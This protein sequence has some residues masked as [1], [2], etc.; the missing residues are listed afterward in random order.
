M[1]LVSLFALLML[2]VSCGQDG[3]GSSSSKVAQR[4]DASCELNGRSVACG[5]IR[6]ADGE[7]VDL[8]E[9]LVDVPVRISNSDIQFL[10]DKT[11]TAQGRRISCNT[12]VKNGEL[13]RFALRGDKLI[14]MTN[15]GT[16]EMRRS[17]GGGDLTGS[18][19]WDGY[20]D[21]GTH[22]IRYMTFIGNNRVIMR[23]TC[24][25]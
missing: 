11:S 9:S 20:V 24:E 23:T 12:Q 25:L 13:Y 1:R 15:N 16:Y 21:E 6:G 18:W 19:V 3:G 7:G 14:I 2:S 10:A 8:L 22:M 5:S 17:N 4:E